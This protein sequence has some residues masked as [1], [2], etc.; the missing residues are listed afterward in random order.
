VHVNPEI[1]IVHQFQKNQSLLAEQLQLYPRGLIGES[2]IGININL[3]YS[4]E[5]QL[6]KNL[7]VLVEAGM[8]NVKR[9]AE[10]YKQ[11]LL[12]EHFT[13]EEDYLMQGSLQNRSS[14]SIMKA[15]RVAHC[16]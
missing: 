14:W 8:N 4:I 6:L 11:Q 10:F 7:H 15:L 1:S 16:R 13:R 3:K 5:H 2:Q 9:L 12:R